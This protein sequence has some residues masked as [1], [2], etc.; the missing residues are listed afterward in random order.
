MDINPI[1]TEWAGVSPALKGALQTAG[2]T[3]AQGATPP[4]DPSLGAAPKITPQIK[5][6]AMPQDAGPAPA[7][8]PMRMADSNP[9]PSLGAPTQPNI[10]VL[11]SSPL[12]TL[13]GDTDHRQQL[14]NA[15]P[16]VSQISH[17]IQG[18]DFGQN[19]PMLG[20]ILGGVAQGA[21]MLGDTLANALP[22]I[23][24]EIPGTTLNHNMQLGQANTALTQDET[25]AG[26][27]AQTRN[28]NAEAGSREEET[29]EAPQ[30]AND[31]HDLSQASAGN[32][33]S[34][35]DERDN[36]HAQYEVHDTQA[37]PLFLNKTTGQAQHLSVN[38]MPVGPKIQTKVV[39]LQI[40]GKDHQVLVNDTD[41]TVIKDMG[42][43]G[44]KPPSVSVNQGTWTLDEDASGKPVMFNSKTGG[45]REAPAGIQKAGT[46]AKGEAKTAPMKASLAYANDYLTTGKPTGPGDEALME[47]Y[48]DLAK[49]STGFRMSQPQQDMLKNSQSWMNSL[50]GKAHHV[51]TG[52]WFTDPQRKE[53]VGTMNDIGKA[54]G[55][56]AANQA[57]SPKEGDAK[58]NSSGDKI[59]YKGGKWGPG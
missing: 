11:G 45:T 54:N 38:G 31:A 32:L 50:E 35:T 29:A 23:G 36:P 39:Q 15:P 28:Q 55:I 10:H 51:T 9:V 2:Q 27:E 12:G 53:I 42:Q 19:H 58:V 30:K 3:L 25:N 49:P 43:G 37:G 40:G 44:I 26:K 1:M 47:K 6:G 57:N 41:G 14:M 22:G 52:T 48:F 56:G 24:R 13:Q 5:A 34:E 21:G 7:A 17:R 20:K 4:V 18:T 16:A 59:V 8:S 33:T 46:F